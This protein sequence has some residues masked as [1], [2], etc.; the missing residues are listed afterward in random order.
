MR[1]IKPAKTFDARFGS[2]L[3]EGILPVFRQ[4]NLQVEYRSLGSLR[5]YI[6]NARRHSKKQLQKLAH[7]I[8]QVG[9]INPIIIDET[10]MILAGH[11]RY[12][13]APLAGLN[14]VPVIVVEGLSEA[15]K[16]SYV[17]SDNR[18]GDESHFDKGQLKAELEGLISLGYDVEL[19][20]FDT[21]EID[22]ILTF[23]EPG[24]D[25]N[26]HLPG[27]KEQPVSRLGD[28]WH[29]GPHRVLCGDARDI[30]CHERVLGGA[31]V[32]LFF[33]DPPYGCA[34]AGNVSGLGSVKHGDFVMGA[35]EQSLPAFGQTLLRPAFRC[36]ASTAAPGAIAFVCTDW[37]ASPHLHDAAQGVFHEQK[38]LIV[39]VKTNAGMG[40]FYRSQHELIHAFKVTPGKHRNNFGLGEGGRHRSNVW[41]Y[42]G[43]NTFRKGR[44]QDLADHSTVKPKAM[45]ADAIR[46][47][48]KRG[49]VV[50]DPFLG[51]GTLLVACAMTGRIG[52]GLE[53]D[54]KYVD[55]ILRR[56]S[57]E[58]GLEPLL[59][60]VTPFSQV[61][62]DRRAE[63][64]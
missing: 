13:A 64:V 38:N 36:M 16:R 54:P 18:L 8:R 28:L 55:V 3:V 49:D 30:A 7:T 29:I 42:P 63:E 60:G 22:S 48:S 4:H 52:R 59:D 47:C 2:I 41:T 43:A 45:V 31:L 23:E 62:A 58:T 27:E 14:M 56:V 37:R 20:G 34:I 40:T 1:P 21:I 26:V 6:G 50:M 15:E 5:P 53:L 57:E 33:T 24:A 25:D 46:D 10:G 17:L 19:T 51:S 44:M 61:A 32:D 11:G 9:W 39:F 35:G 12:E